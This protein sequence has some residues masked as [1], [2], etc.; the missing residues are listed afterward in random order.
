MTT[1]QLVG[2]ALA[3]VAMGISLA[4]G[5]LHLLPGAALIFLIALGHRLYFGP[6]GASNWVLVAMASVGV[7]SMILDF[8]ATMVGARKLGA[9]RRGMVGAL[10]GGL[11]GLFAGLPGLLLG[12]FLGAF[13]LEHLGGRPVKDAARAGIGAALGLVAGSAGT[14]LC[15][16]LMVGIF[17]ISV[18]SNSSAHASAM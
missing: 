5:T 14:F 9:T 17:V 11:A 13:L 6:A 12:P 4:G 1:E 10:I 15:C 16:A 3:L 2:L 18:W 8:A 7:L